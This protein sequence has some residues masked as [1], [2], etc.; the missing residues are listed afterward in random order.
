MTWATDADLD[1][2]DTV[3]RTALA[4]YSQAA[5]SRGDSA[6]STYEGLRT[7]AET[8]ILLDLGGRGITSEMI[9]NTSV[10]TPVEVECALWK[11]YDAVE[12]DTSG[13]ARELYAARARKYETRYR[14]SVQTVNPVMN[15]RGVGA[16]FSWRRG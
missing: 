12:Q 3:A 7:I 2:E 6:I 13:E 5:V 16:S 8:R 4:A 9:T 10:M 15:I 14:A 1:A 11:L